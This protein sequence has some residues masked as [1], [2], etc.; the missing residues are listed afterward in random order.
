MSTPGWSAGTS[1][2]LSPLCRWESGSVRTRTYSQSA[3]IPKEVHTFCPFTTQSSPSRSARVRTDARSEPAPGSLKPC[4]H[5]SSTARIGGRKRFFCSSLPIASSIGPS[6]S[7][8]FPVARYGALARAYSYSKTISSSSPSPRP[9]Y[10]RGQLMPSQFPADSSRSQARRTS[11]AAPSVGPPTPRCAAN[12]PT[13]C[14]ASQ[15]R[16]SSRKSRT[17]GPKSSSML[18]SSR[19]FRC[20]AGWRAA[21]G[22]T[23]VCRAAPRSSWPA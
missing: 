20:R 12:S 8:A 19:G 5:S 14:S 11:Q 15:S 7:R 21:P 2:M 13:R 4:P 6:R 16:S 9:P 22:G 1:S 3:W 18:A 10:S 17:A 23:T